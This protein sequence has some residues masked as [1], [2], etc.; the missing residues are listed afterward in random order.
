MDPK[1]LLNLLEDYKRSKIN[2]EEALEIL[3]RLPFEDLG[4]ARVEHHRQVRK[5][6]PEVIFGAGKTPDQILGIV[7]SLKRNS[8]NVLITRSDESVFRLIEQEHPEAVFHASSKTIT[9][10]RNPERTGKG[11]VLVLSA[12]TADLPV[13]EEALV[14]ADFFGNP[15][16]SVYDVGVAGLHRLLAERERLMKAR[17]IIAVAGMEGALPSVV[18]GLVSAPV[19]AVPTSVGYGVHFGGVAPLLA[20]LN[21]CAALAVVNIDNGFGAGQIA[22]IINHL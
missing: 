3:K 1:F 7:Q 15:T 18:A 19:I 17:V 2:Q 4:Y 22:S 9:I 12:G 8:T 10:G 13:A 11:T 5:G 14:T 20:M 6:S 21:S 16:D